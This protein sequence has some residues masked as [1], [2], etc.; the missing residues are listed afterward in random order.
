[1][2][3]CRDI[4]WDPAVSW[5]TT[6]PNLSSCL[7]DVLVSSASFL[8]I[9]LSP[10]WLCTLYSRPTGLLA[11]P[12]GGR[13]GTIL[14]SLR[15]LC[16]LICFIASICI[17]VLQSGLCIMDLVSSSSLA[18]A[19]FISVVAE[20]LMVRRL[21]HTSVV[22][23]SFCVLLT[24]LLLPGLK[25]SIEDL[26]WSTDDNFSLQLLNIVRWV[27]VLVC[28]VLQGFSNTS[29]LP[30]DTTPEVAASAL[31]SFF[32]SWFTG[33]I[34][35]G[36]KKPLVQ[37]DIPDL[38]P[39]V[40]VREN[41]EKLRLVQENSR[42]QGTKF[43]LTRNLFFCFAGHFLIG[44][45]LFFIRLIFVFSTPMILKLTVQFISD[46]DVPLWRG[47]F[48]AIVMALFNFVAVMLDHQG[49]RLVCISANQ[50]MTAVTAAVYRKS[51][52]LS[53]L[54]RQKFTTGEITNFMSVDAKRL[55]ETIPFSYFIFIS[56]FEIVICLV[57]IYYNIGVSMFAGIG[58]L[59]IVI[60]INLI[61]SSKAE[62]VLDDQLTAKDKRI[63]LMSEIL[64]GMKVLKLYA[65]EKPFMESINKIRNSE[66]DIIKC[67]AKLWALVNFTFGSVPF[68]MTLA[69]FFT[70]TFSN[71]KNV[72][73]AD[74]IFVC[75][76]L[77]SLIRLPLTLFPLAL[78]DVLKLGVSLKRLDEF[79]NADE[80]EN[81]DEVEFPSKTSS[82]IEISSGT[83]TWENKEEPILSSIDVEIKHG[84]L[85]AVVGLVGAGKSSFLSAILGE[86]IRLQG[87]VRRSGRTA[88]VAQQAWIQN[89]TVKENIL[90]G[91]TV[92]ESLYNKVIQKCCLTSDIQQLPAGDSTEIGENGINV[93]G[94][95]KQ[96]IAL[97][98]AVY[99]QADVYL[100]DDP[101]A[102]LDAHVGKAVFNDVLSN[103]GILK[104]ATRVLVTHNLSALKHVD[105]ILVFRE[106]KLEENGSFEEL[107]HNRGPFS[108]F[109]KNHL[110]NPTEEDKETIKEISSVVGEVHIASSVEKTPEVGSVPHSFRKML[111]DGS[112]SSPRFRILQDTTSFDE[113]RIYGLP[114]TPLLA[115]APSQTEH[116]MKKQDSC[117]GDGKLTE[118]EEALT[119]NVKMAIYLKYM[120]SLGVTT[121]VFTVLMYFFCESITTGSSLMLAL[122]AD[123]PNKNE[124][125]T[126]NTYMIV[127]GALGISQTAFFLFKELVLFLAC[128]K[129]S[130]SIH[131]VL[132]A[133]IMHSP[134]S[135]F[136]TNPI[137]RILNRFSS[138]IDSVDQTIPFLIDDFMNCFVEVV[139]II[140]VISYSTPWF[141]LLLLPIAAVYLTL[142]KFYISSARQFRRL[143][144]I[145]KSPIF[146]H[147]TET[148]TGAASIRAFRAES[149]FI[150]ESEDLVSRNN[151][152]QWS[153]LNS[154]RWLGTR[155]ENLGNVIILVSAVLVVYGRGVVTPGLAGLSISYSLLATGSMNWMIRMMCSL[156]TNSICLERIFEYTEKPQEDAW[157][158]PDDTSIDPEWP[159][160]GKIEFCDV[161]V[162]YREGLPSVI[163]NLSLT[164]RGG[165]RIGVCGRTGA[166]KSTLSLLLFRMMEHTQGKILID[167]VDISKLGLQNLRSKLTII[168]QDPVLFSSTLRFN[169]D[170]VGQHSDTELIRVLNLAGLQEFSSQLDQEVQ[171]KGENYSVGQRQLLCL[172]R[173]LL[174]NSKLLLLDEATAAVDVQTDDIVQQTIRKQF[175]GCTVLTI[176]HR[177]N[178]IMDSDRVMV[179]D[180][181]E[182]M[183]LDS[184]G[185]LLDQSSSMFFSLAK[186]SGI[187]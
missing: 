1:M 176:A 79:L 187:V 9:F 26:L 100:L 55:I 69:T 164:I 154:N 64:S 146:S 127:Y 17:P 52:R 111:S 30:L 7:Q 58:V 48:Y 184:P 107:L 144:M 19:V 60:P 13:F 168:P 166:G 67:I 121:F 116:I 74:L 42:K 72:L 56:P 155:C 181:G 16:F 159:Q 157:D 95:Q 135:F 134:M 186:Q 153:S 29:L 11:A 185:K 128:A 71:S 140:V 178:T 115:A 150:G 32:F 180:K 87:D 91:R 94:G 177:L 174:R 5:N 161:S 118:D 14:V 117:S 73:T 131:N 179:L 22:Q 109:L 23:T 173:A 97:A 133:R 151:Q 104:N 39:T 106:G 77:F 47:Y 162:Q 114:C 81:A 148:V 31:S 152:C 24:I 37:D 38:H 171:E 28:T 21:Q 40:C 120:K 78:I 90:F 25:L 122:W 182:L 3:V 102:A 41:A 183:E 83:F 119:G 147:F 84:E 76:S 129:A 132:L 98:R 136:D 138:D 149:R 18:A 61:T 124:P 66:V 170:P 70:F 8:Y 113:E 103:T 12:R 142:Q 93:S 27:F 82:A 143:E 130:R 125:K 63:K 163:K 123:D 62:K 36:W 6:N 112:N 2:E 108:E 46:Q 85:V 156:E 158:T 65:W 75:L 15:L 86:M 44:L 59:V 139:G 68:L 137:G 92:D 4:L 101:L 175:Q 80:L 35:K 167:G 99:Q 34:W 49:L 45:L 51:L 33:L 145:S 53:N 96:R 169:L 43:N 160:Q 50:M 20:C 10:A 172:A 141:L 89:L 165:E 126:R 110:T 54:A 105:R 57:L 88:Y